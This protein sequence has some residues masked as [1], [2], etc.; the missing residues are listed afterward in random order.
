MRTI[1]DGIAIAR[2]YH[3]SLRLVTLEGELINPGGSMNGGDVYKRQALG[4]GQ[5]REASETGRYL[6]VFFEKS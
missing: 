4:L 5:D 6:S 1:D 3:Q 2:K